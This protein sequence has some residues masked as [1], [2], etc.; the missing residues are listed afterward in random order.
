M[1]PIQLPYPPSLNRYWRTF[2]NRT[3][4]SAE[5]LAYKREVAALARQAGLQGVF[6][7]GVV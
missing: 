1:T 4:V 2:R 6:A 7:G 3:V 5:G